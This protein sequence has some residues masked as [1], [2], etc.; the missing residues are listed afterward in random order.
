MP[1][2]EQDLTAWAMTQ[3]A[4]LRA[5]GGVVSRGENQPTDLL[6]SL[7]WEDLAEEIEGLAR[8]DRRELG[9]RLALIIEHLAKLEFSRPVEPLGGWSETILRERGEIELILQDSPSLRGVVPDILADRTEVAVQLAARSL[10]L[11]GETPSAGKLRKSRSGAGY[12]LGDV[13]GSWLPDTP[14][15]SCPKP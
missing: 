10:E 14:S 5:L 3:A 2:D 12:R 8:R 1:E 4:A 13:L 11:H 9:S 6:R 7:D 15:P